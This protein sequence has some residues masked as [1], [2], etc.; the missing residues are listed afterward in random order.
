MPAI[1]AAAS[2]VSSEPLAAPIGIAL[3]KSLTTLAPPDN[4]LVAADEI[5][6]L[7]L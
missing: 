6:S 3:D 2:N 1:S 4:V 5:F 7:F